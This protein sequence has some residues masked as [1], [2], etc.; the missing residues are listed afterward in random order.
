MFVDNLGSC[1]HAKDNKK[2]KTV[3]PTCVYS[4]LCTT[5]FQGLVNIPYFCD[6]ESNR[7]KKIGGIL[8]K[9]LVEILQGSL[10]NE[11]IKNLMISVTKVNVTVDL[12]IARVN[13]SVFPAS[14][15]PA[16]LEGI[17]SNGP[18]IKHALALRVKNQLRKMPSLAFYL[19]ESLEYIDQIDRSLKGEDN[20]ID[21]PS[22]LDKRKKI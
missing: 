19:D 18:L 12:S 20:P 22:L 11:G 6:M 13:L 16:L 8:Q 1:L 5:I 14:E 21:D 15:G 9:D 7:Q 2:I 17:K 4:V 10:R 3:F